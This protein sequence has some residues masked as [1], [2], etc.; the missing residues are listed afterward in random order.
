MPVIIIRRKGT[1]RDGSAP[2]ILS[3]YGSYGFSQRPEFL[4]WWQRL[5][6]DAGGVYA[7]AQV[8]GGGEFGRRW[9]IA[10]SHSRKQNSFD[11]FAAA[12]RHLI[13]RKYTSQEKL[14]FSGKSAGALLVGAVAVQHPQ[15]ARA[16]VARSGV[17]DMLRAELEV[18][19]HSTYRTAAR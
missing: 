16:V 3:A 6:L 14:A 10:G 5:W 7:I 13:D 9:R 2:A 8:R 15:L 19:A 18:T 4:T 17:F 11:D 12:A 1:A